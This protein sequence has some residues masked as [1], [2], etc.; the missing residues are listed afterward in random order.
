L[1][2]RNVS[3]SPSSASSSFDRWVDVHWYLMGL[4]FPALLAAI[5][6][7]AVASSGYWWLWPVTVLIAV[8]TLSVIV[9]VTSRSS[10]VDTPGWHLR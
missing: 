10:P 9:S 7:G 5:L 4:L 3:S 2:E 8:P 6:L 1:S